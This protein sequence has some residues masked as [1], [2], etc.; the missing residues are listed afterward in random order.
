M[1]KYYSS[2]IFQVFHQ[3]EEYQIRRF[4]KYDNYF[5]TIISILFAIISAALTTTFYF[6]NLSEEFIEKQE[7]IPINQKV[8][9]FLTHFYVHAWNTLLQLMYREFNTRNISII[10]SFIEEINR[11]LNKPDRSVIINAQRTVLRFMEFR[12]NFT[13]NVEF[14]K[15]FIVVDI[16]LMSGIIIYT[17]VY[18]AIY[19]MFN[20]ICILYLILMLIHFSWTIKTGLKVNKL[21]EELSSKLNRWEN[22]RIEGINSIEM[23]VLGRIVQRF[24][25]N[26][27]IEEDSV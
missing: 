19:N 6:N 25:G 12:S 17:M 20:I 5:S 21:S 4:I 3:I 18:T 10:E 13:K 16:L 1:I 27:N 24:T 14:I 11:Q 15:Y 8:Q 2:N 23:K 9:I 7:L 22:F 26:E